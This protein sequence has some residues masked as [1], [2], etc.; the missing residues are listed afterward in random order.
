M[1]KNEYVINIRFIA[2]ILVVLG[3]SIILY[4]T[5]WS[6]F[7]PLHEY[8]IL[9]YIKKA[10][11]IIQMPLY[12]SISGH[13]FYYSVRRKPFKAVVLD[14]IKRLLIP[15]AFIAFCW[16]LPIRLLIGYSG[17]RSGLYDIIFHKI[18]L[19]SDNGHLW[20]LPT[21]FICFLATF[22]VYHLLKKTGKASRCLGIAVLV[23]SLVLS[24]LP[25]PHIHQPYI[26]DFLRYYCWFLFG[27]LFRPNQI[28]EISKRLSPFYLALILIIS[29]CFGLAYYQNKYAVVIV[30]IVQLLTLYSIV[31]DK[32]SSAV[33]RISDD[34]FGIYLFHSPLI[35]ITFTFL[36]DQNPFIVIL[37]NFVAFGGL[38]FLIT[39][40]L[41]KIGLG[42][43]IGEKNENYFVKY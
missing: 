15:F 9:D 23:A 24:F 12:F 29:L 40:G 26:V 6:I 43:L 30:R 5:E 41:K 34:S 35:Y 10:I 14:K 1:K 31:P 28:T 11:N 42:F 22:P 20:F 18:L 21:L 27:Y 4:S 32:T 13:L 39:R 38:S 2:I 3:H 7:Q 36:K 37:I 25:L 17:Y 8:A 19:G 33:N 16:L